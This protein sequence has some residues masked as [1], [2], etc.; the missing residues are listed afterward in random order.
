MRTHADHN[1]SSRE[2]TV[3]GC[4]MHVRLWERSVPPGTPP[5]VLVHGLSMSG[6]YL[7]PTAERLAPD[8]TVYAPDLPGFGESEAP[9]RVLDVPK[10]A[11]A[12]AEWMRDWELDSAVLAGN[13]LGCQIITE[14]A[15]RWPGL[16]SAAVLVGPTPDPTCRSVP[17]LLLRAGRDVVGESLALYPILA[18]EY[19]RAGVRRSWQTLKYLV[20][21]PMED[22]LSRVDIP[23]VVVRGD[24]DRIVSAA[25][26]EWMAR[27]LPHGRLVTVPDAAHAVNFGHP[28]PVA[29][30]VRTLAASV[31]VG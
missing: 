23:V 27:A 29:A 2:A 31:R 13:S 24:R 4:R 16:A 10:L 9:N 7:V 15:V 6:A 5:V 1:G 30:A 17:R 3:G 28:E 26:A 25:W 22:R 20:A 12:L 11:E 8:Y 19:L 14:L 18:R 21:D